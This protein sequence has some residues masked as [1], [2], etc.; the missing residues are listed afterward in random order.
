[1]TK[2]KLC[3][4]E[5]FKDRI[6][7]KNK[8]FCSFLAQEQYTQGHSIFMT[9]KHIDGIENLCENDN[10]EIST[11]FMQAISKVAKILKNK[12]PNKPKKIYI[13]LLN[14]TGHLHFHLLP[15]YKYDSAGFSFMKRIGCIEEFIQLASKRNNSINNI[16]EL[17]AI[18][19]KNN[20]AQK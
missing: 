12:L 6:F 10:K 5:K 3:C 20:G 7:F 2:C 19:K 17:A 1:M 11:E 18:L 16:K 14:E 15:R 4:Q 13:T 8:N 9:I